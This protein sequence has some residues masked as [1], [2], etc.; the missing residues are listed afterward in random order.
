MEA[1]KLFLHKSFVERTCLL[2]SK[3]SAPR[4][5]ITETPLDTLPQIGLNRFFVD[6][7]FKDREY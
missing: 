3:S 4:L 1:A 5:E 6:A 2:A 7:S